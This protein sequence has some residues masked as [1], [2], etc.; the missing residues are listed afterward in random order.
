[1]KSNTLN[2]PATI[3]ATVD[4]S[5]DNIDW[6]PHLSWTVEFWA[7][8]NVNNGAAALNALPWFSF[9]FDGSNRFNV[10]LGPSVSLG[11]VQNIN[12]GYIPATGSWHHYAI[13]R[14]GSDN[15]NIYI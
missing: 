10:Q 15:V 11:P 7:K 9:F 12:T 13:S 14:D 2:L 3:Y 5:V 8:V 6:L 4:N 1:M